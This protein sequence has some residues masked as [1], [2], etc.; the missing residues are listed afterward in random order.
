MTSAEGTSESFKQFLPNPGVK[1]I[2]VSCTP[3][4]DADT[5]T[6]SDLVTIKGYYLQKT[7]GSAITTSATFSGNVLTLADGST[8]TPITGIIWGE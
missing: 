8:V 7:D 4:N 5:I 2:Y 1:V 3:V 6:V